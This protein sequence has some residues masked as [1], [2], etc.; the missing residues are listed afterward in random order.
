[1]VAIVLLMIAALKPWASSAPVDPRLGVAEPTAGSAASD[2]EQAVESASA[3][4]SRSP[5]P[6]DV[7]C[8]G[9]WRLVSLTN[10]ATWR[11]KE[12]LPIQPSPGLGPFDRRIPFV[13]LEADVVALGVCGDGQ[14]LSLPDGGVLIRAAWLVTPGARPTA[15]QVAIEPL[16]APS[17]PVALAR[18]Y[19]PERV[20]RVGAGG[21]WPSGRYV[22]ELG[23]PGSSSPSW[24]GIVVPDMADGG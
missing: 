16:T 14:E 24:L 4:P 1:M 3:S 18:L 12:W 13:D 17:E 8:H 5:G 15:K 19:R 6:Y 20:G 11:V 7:E 21:L 22:L 23:L 2:G 9:G 10:L